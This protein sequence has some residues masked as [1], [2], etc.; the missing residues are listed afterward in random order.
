MPLAFVLSGILGIA[1]GALY[2]LWRGRGFKD[3]LLH[4]LAG[5]LGFILGHY[6]GSWLLPGM[7]LKLGDLHLLEGVI[8]SGGALG[9]VDYLKL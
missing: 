3:L 2:H 8:V 5:A 9:L 7:P 1:C 4:L 6:A